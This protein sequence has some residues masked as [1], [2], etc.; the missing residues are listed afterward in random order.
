MQLFPP[1]AHSTTGTPHVTFSIRQL[2]AGAHCTA[3]GTVRT[4]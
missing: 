2:H 4:V 1:T 3:G